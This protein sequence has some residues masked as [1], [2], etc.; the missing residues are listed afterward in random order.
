MPNIEMLKKGLFHFS[1]LIAAVISVT[2]ALASLID[3]SGL[4]DDLID[5]NLSF[6]YFIDFITFAIGAILGFYLRSATKESEKH[7]N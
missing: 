7:D 1:T 4:K 3:L 5:A 6:S 2:M